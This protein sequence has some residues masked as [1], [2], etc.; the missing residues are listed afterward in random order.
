MTG[1]VNGLATIIFMAQLE[2]FQELDWRRSFDYFDTNRDGALGIEEISAVFRRDLPDLSA[3]QLATEMDKVLLQVDTSGDGSVSFD[4]F[5]ADKFHLI[6]DGHDEHK[7]WR[8][9]SQDT[10]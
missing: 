9:L 6:H 5:Q 3:T 4:E 10:T 7:M 1:F 8:T 2:S